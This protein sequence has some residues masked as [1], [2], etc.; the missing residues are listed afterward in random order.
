MQYQS[1]HKI[2]KFTIIVWVHCFEKETFS[3]DVHDLGVCPV[4]R[5]AVLLYWGE[6][7]QCAFFLL[8]QFQSD[9]K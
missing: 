9:H 6:M 1:N 2:I 7:A 8:M 5:H 4:N 3:D